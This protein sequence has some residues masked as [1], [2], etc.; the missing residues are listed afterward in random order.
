MTPYTV[1]QNTDGQSPSF[2]EEDKE[3]FSQD[4]AVLPSLNGPPNAWHDGGGI[5][6]LQCAGAFF[7]FFNSWG[8][9]NTFGT[10]LLSICHD[11]HFSVADLPTAQA[12]IK[13]TMSNLSP[14]RLPPALPG[15]DHYKPSCSSSAVL[16]QALSTI[17]AI[18][19]ALYEAVAFWL[20]WA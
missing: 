3:K 2:R 14:A 18:Y 5:A 17:M 6:W 10:C 7:L 1:S 15:L 12:F 9:V 16:L 11:S 4:E 19:K 20:S 8:L 13:P